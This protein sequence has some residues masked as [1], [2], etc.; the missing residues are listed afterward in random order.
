LQPRSE[1]M[2]ASGWERSIDLGLIKTALSH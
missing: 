2:G 1:Q